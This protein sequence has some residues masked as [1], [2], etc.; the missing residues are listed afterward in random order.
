M[1]DELH[2]DKAAASRRV[3]DAIGRGYLKNLE[4]RRGRP[5]RLVLGEAMPEGAE[6]L[7]APEELG[8][9]SNG[10]A[11][12]RD[13]EGVEAPPPP[14]FDGEGTRERRRV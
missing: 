13:P 8:G 14:P 3:R 10:C 9:A 4:D 11:V 12:D 6:V 7:P 2:I 5:A 1:A